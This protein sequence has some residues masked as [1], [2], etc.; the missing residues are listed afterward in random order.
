MFEKLTAHAHQR[1]RPVVPN[2]VAIT[3]CTGTTLATSPSFGPR[4]CT[5]D[6]QNMISRFL[7]S[8]IR[9]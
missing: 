2:F 4:D 5:S 9:L 8:L 7:K 3:S 6:A 1:N